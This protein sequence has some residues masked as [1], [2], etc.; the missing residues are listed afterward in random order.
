MF[1]LNVKYKIMHVQIKR[2]IQDTK[3]NKYNTKGWV[4]NVL[5]SL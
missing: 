5:C 2:K 3:R 4:G 1:K